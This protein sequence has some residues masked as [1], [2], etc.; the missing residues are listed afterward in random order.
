MFTRGKEEK[1]GWVRMDQGG[2]WTGVSLHSVASGMFGMIVVMT[3]F[4]LLPLNSSFS[5]GLLLSWVIAPVIA[6]S[7]LGLFGI[8][9]RP[10]NG[11]ES[12]VAGVVSYAVLGTAVTLKAP[13]IGILI[14]AF[15][16]GILAVLA[17]G[18]PLAHSKSIQSRGNTEAD[19]IGSGEL[20]VPIVTAAVCVGALLAG[21]AVLSAASPPD[22]GCNVHA[23]F[24]STWE[25]GSVELMHVTGDSVPASQLSVEINQSSVKWSLL[26]ADVNRTGTVKAGDAARVPSVSPNTTVEVVYYESD[27]RRTLYADSGGT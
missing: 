18:L 27:C 8:V 23:S 11:R 6:G 5:A 2:H 3:P 17:Y 9:K 21:G 22:N 1:S 7:A 14:S 24:Q 16:A 13:A 10:L 20:F 12:V 15:G 19:G 4:G 26:S 25:N